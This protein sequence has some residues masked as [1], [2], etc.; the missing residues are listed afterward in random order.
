MEKQIIGRR[1]CGDVH[2]ESLSIISTINNLKSMG[3]KET[4]IRDAM[5]MDSTMQYR[6]IKRLALRGELDT[7]KNII[8]ILV[9][10]G[11]NPKDI[12]EVTKYYYGKAEKEAMQKMRDSHKAKKE[13]KQMSKV[14]Q[15]NIL[16]RMLMEDKD[17]DGWWVRR[18]TEENRC[19]VQVDA[20]YLFE[21][22]RDD[23]N[24]DEMFS[25]FV[26]DIIENGYY[27]SDVV[28]RRGSYGYQEGLLEQYGL[29][30]TDGEG[31]DVMGYLTAKD[32]YDCWKKYVL[33][34]SAEG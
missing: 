16:E 9:L 2:P 32:V 12:L 27:V 7:I 8:E 15:M 4:E 14:L 21:E 5:A 11:F 13:E 10:K 29:V 30:D 23:K 18:R 24:E 3:F 33:E 1:H 26:E 6:R 31:D 25:D 22:K 19:N 20:M 28:C 17:M 34:H